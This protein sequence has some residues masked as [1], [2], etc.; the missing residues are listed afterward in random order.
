MGSSSPR[1]ISLQRE[2]LTVAEELGEGGRGS[3]C[4]IGVPGG[5]SQ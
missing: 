2:L 4:E 1:H 3:K 5:A